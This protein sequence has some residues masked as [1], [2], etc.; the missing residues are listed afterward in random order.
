MR[1][2]DHPP[3][4]PERSAEE[5]RELARRSADPGARAWYLQWAKAFDRLTELSGRKGKGR[6][7]PN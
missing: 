5:L 6:D 7:K 2:N 3:T 1:E 4:A